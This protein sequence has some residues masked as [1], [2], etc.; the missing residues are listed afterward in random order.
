MVCGL[1]PF[2]CEK[3]S[4][5]GALLFSPSG[6]RRIYYNYRLETTTIEKFGLYHFYPGSNVLKVVT[7]G[8]NLSCKLC[9][10]Y[11]TIFLRKEAYDAGLITHKIL[12]LLA[13]DSINIVG[14]YCNSILDLDMIAS[15]R[16]FFSGRIIAVTHGF[17]SSE[18]Q[19]KLAT[20]VDALII[21]FFGFSKYSYS[22]ICSVPYGFKYAL[23]LL[24]FL[25]KTYRHV[26]VEFYVIPGITT[27]TEF[28]SFLTELSRSGIPIILHI[29]RFVPN[30]LMNC[31]SPTS[32]RDLLR[33]YN[34]ARKFHQYVYADVWH[35]SIN[36][37]YCTNGHIIIKREGWKTKFINIKN[38]RCAKCGV[39]VPGFF[40]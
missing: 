39:A 36:D 2:N 3:L 14:F 22:K 17:G 13:Y 7:Y 32:T 5:C 4:L 23:R 16:K 6:Y 28:E 38:G 34:I 26:E 30:F 19:R 18:A 12:D 37:T 11:R 10:E 35:S 15:L 9:D 8:C 20:L 21:R 31:K 33:Y 1:C 25:S 24:N 40:D 29:K 27:I